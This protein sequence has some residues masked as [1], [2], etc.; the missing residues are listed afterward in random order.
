MRG[1]HAHKEDI[2]GDLGQ[3]VHKRANQHGGQFCLF[4]LDRAARHDTRYCASPYKTPLTI[5][6]MAD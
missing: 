6:G 4:I 1:K 3:A 2:E 5:I